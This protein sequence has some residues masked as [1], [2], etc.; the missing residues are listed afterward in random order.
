MPQTM[1]IIEARRKLTSLPE[2]FEKDLDEGAIAVTRRGKPVLAIM[3]WS[4]YESIAETIEVLS[5]EHL[6]QELRHSLEEARAGQ[7]I[8]WEQFKKELGL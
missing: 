8:P 4:L 2:E 5:D 1:P 6:M 3:P 7:A